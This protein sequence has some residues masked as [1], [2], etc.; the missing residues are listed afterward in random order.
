M[1]LGH[2]KLTMHAKQQQVR[3]M[4]APHGAMGV[5]GWCEDQTGASV[6]IEEEVRCMLQ[7][8]CQAA[9]GF[10]I[11][12]RSQIRLSLNQWLFV[13]LPFTAQSYPVSWIT[14]FPYV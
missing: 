7:P 10:N 8:H 5:G 2:N 9:G 11:D 4:K 1:R 14:S 12:Y 6:G 13:A 3:L